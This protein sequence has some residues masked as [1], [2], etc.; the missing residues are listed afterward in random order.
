MICKSTVRSRHARRYALRQYL[1]GSIH[2]S[3]R[4]AGRERDDLTGSGLAH[5]PTEGSRNMLFIEAQTPAPRQQRFSG[6]VM[7]VA[8]LGHVCG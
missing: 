3:L 6:L 5:V 2:V 4:G 1:A 8:Y 7:Y